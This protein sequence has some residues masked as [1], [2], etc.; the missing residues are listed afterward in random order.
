MFSIEQNTFSEIYE[1]ILTYLYYNPEYVS[2]PR[3][4]IIHEVLD[5]VFTIKNPYSNLYKNKVRSPNMKYLKNEL[6]LYYR[7]VN[8]AD[9]FV[10]ASK[11]WDKIKNDDGTVNSAYGYL[12][13]KETYEMSQWK[14]AF[15]SLISDKD[16][17]QAFMH[18]NKPHHQFVGNKDQVCTLNM[19]FNIR[20]NK[21]NASVMMR[22]S[23]IYFGLV[24]DVPFFTSLMEMMRLLLL[25]VYPELVLGSY[26]HHS[27]SLHLYDR[28]RAEIGRMLDH[29]F[30]EDGL[31]PIAR[32]LVNQCGEFQGYTNDNFFEGWL[33]DR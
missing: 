17:R 12:I 14:W 15:E 1:S 11:F 24:Y 10:K 7:G 32:P 23:D 19:L 9:E 20:D 22:S 5:F 16:T 28:N 2:A 13:F 27:V 3:G 26:T 25:P 33:N 8:D 18:F 31:P 30:E 4:Q 29:K 21:L 6:D